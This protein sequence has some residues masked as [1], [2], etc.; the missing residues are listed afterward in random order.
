[1]LGCC[2]NTQQV[3]CLM[4]GKHK[5]DT[6][7]SSFSATCHSVNYHSRCKLHFK[8]KIKEMKQKTVYLQCDKTYVLTTAACFCFH[9]SYHQAVQKD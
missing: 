8:F 9:T 4:T 3:L 5:T 6:T 2:P 7:Q 1:M